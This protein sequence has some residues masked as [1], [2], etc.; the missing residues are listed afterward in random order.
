MKAISLLQPWASLAVMGI[1]SIETRNWNT[2]FRG[3]ILIHASKGKSGKIFAEQ[4]LFKRHI[5]DFKLIPY[6]AI[7]GSVDIL[8]VIHIENLFMKD[9]LINKLSLENKA[10]GDYGVG[11]YAWI[12]ESPIVF[13]MPIAF[14]GMMGIWD[15]P[16]EILKNLSDIN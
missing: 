15:F 11:R 2:K 14:K 8:N 3:R 6:G 5:P 12:L 13:D 16:D 9:E 10:F 1:K 4:D 7:I